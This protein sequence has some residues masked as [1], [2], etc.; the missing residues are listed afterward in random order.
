MEGDNMKTIYTV[1][2]YLGTVL[3]LLGLAMSV[4]L[5]FRLNIHKVLGDLTGYT[6]RKDIARIREEVHNSQCTSNLESQEQIASTKEQTIPKQQEIPRQQEIPKQEDTKNMQTAV[7]DGSSMNT[8]VLME[9]MSEEGTTGIPIDRNPTLVLNSIDDI[10]PATETQAMPSGK[11]QSVLD[12]VVTH[13]EKHIDSK[14]G[15]IL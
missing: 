9:T 13:T 1:M 6:A 2:L 4:I 12:I 11:T 3:A 7:L 15:D 5:Y 8:N 14:G 10:I